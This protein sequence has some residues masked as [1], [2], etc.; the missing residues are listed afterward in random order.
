MPDIFQQHNV[1][2]SECYANVS[3]SGTVHEIS[4]LAEIYPFYTVF[5]NNVNV[6]RKRTVVVQKTNTTEV[7]SL[8]I[9]GSCEVLSV[10][11]GS[12]ICHANMIQ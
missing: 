8:Q 3:Q 4:A 12:E 1:C 9:Y 2:T 11:E 6:Y 10:Q 7:E 5:E